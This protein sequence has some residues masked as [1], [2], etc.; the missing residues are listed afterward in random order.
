MKGSAWRAGSERALTRF[1]RKKESER[2][3]IKVQTAPC[4]G[5]LRTER[6][7]ATPINTSGTAGTPRPSRI[8]L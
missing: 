3:F 6:Y 5:G 8:K 7:G 4:F 1:A 2:S